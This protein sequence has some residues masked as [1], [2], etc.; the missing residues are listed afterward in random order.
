MRR[1]TMTFIHLSFCKLQ[2]Q[3]VTAITA[4]KANNNI[5]S[6]TRDHRCQA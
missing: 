2:H 3:L 4:G 1:M 5:K 6:S